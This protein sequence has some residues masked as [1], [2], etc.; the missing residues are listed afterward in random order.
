MK[1]ILTLAMALGLIAQS[2]PVNAATITSVY[3][4]ETDTADKNNTDDK[5]MY[6]V[7]ENEYF[8]Y[9]DDSLD[10]TNI[11]SYTAS[12][13]YGIAYYQKT[14]YVNSAEQYFHDSIEYEGFNDDYG[15][16]YSGTLY[17]GDIKKT[18]NGWRAKYTGYLYVRG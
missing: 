17:L 8:Y 9:V 15:I 10:V 3:N 2:I 7:N 5:V 14:V 6:Q 16:W 4:T 18:S 12:A 1:K 11:E 13:L